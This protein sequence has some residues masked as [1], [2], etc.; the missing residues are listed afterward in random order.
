MSL[1]GTPAPAGGSLFGSAPASGGSSLFG[2]S[3]PAP[4]GGSLFG[5]PAAAPS[6]GSSLFGNTAPAT[7]GSSLF[8]STAPATGG[9]LFGSSPAAP[10]GSSLFGSSPA[11]PNGGAFS[12]SLFSGVPATSTGFGAA[13]APTTSL[14]G[15]TQ[16]P[17]ATGGSLFGSAPQ[18]QAQQQQQ[19]AVLPFTSVALALQRHADIPDL[20]YTKMPTSN[21]SDGT[22]GAPTTGS[23]GAPQQTEQAAAECI[24][25]GVCPDILKKTILDLQIEVSTSMYLC[26]Y[27]SMFIINIPVV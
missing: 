6:G 27:V 23:V 15:A 4:A 18:G 3:T 10:A 11:A 21:G 7:G 8:G 19:A 20:R 9:S 14:F 26:I 16:A 2:S 1:F 13:P 12:G 22:A 24:K 17:A 25:A 5:A